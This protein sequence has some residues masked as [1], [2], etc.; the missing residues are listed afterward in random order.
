MRWDSGMEWDEARRAGHVI[1]RASITISGVCGRDGIEMADLGEN[2][3][4][5]VRGEMGSLCFW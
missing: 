5:N 3:M 1:L 2:M 4:R